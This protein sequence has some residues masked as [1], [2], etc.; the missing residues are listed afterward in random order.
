[1]TADIE[2]DLPRG[3]AIVGAGAIGQLIGARLL[4]ARVPVTLIGRPE[5]MRAV[6][7]HGLVLERPR[8]RPIIL[9][10]IDAVTSWSDLEP[11][12]IANIGLVILTTKVHDTATAAADLSGHVPA[13]IPLLVLQ[14][15][16]GGVDLAR[17][18]AGS[19]PLLAGVT[20]LVATRPQPGV[21][22]SMSSRGGLG[23]ASV[24]APTLLL[25]RVAQQLAGTG[26]PTQVYADYRA[27]AWSKLLLNIL[28]NAV[29]AIVGLPPQRVFQDLAL[30]RLEI[31]AFREALAVMRAQSL[32]PVPLPGYPVPLL[33]RAMGGLPVP[34]LH[35]LLPRLLAGGR[36]GKKPS[37]QIDLEQGRPRSEVEYLNG[38]VVR[39]GLELGVP[40]PANA[41]IY[42]TLLAMVQGTIPREAYVADPHSLLAPLR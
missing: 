16:A 7:E 24:T 28:G 21:V 32:A 6:R 31:A 23:L 11:A 33:V 26:L 35:R 17:N 42:R 1:M 3:V 18:G 36:A 29:P 25:S 34:I 13:E 41:L 2:N 27:M 37:L 9:R 5:A 38:A 22:R 10:D 19:R 30:C 12:E 39:A 40:V 15:G 14:N 20:T 4:R 8:R